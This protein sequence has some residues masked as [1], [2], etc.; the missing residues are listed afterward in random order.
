MENKS[1]PGDRSNEN[2]LSELNYLHQV[3]VEQY[4]EVNKLLNERLN[5]LNSF[6]MMQDVF[7]NIDL[8]GNSELILPIGEIGFATTQMKDNKKILMSVGAGFL[9]EE[10][11]ENAKRIT[12]KY[13][14]KESS[15]IEKL[16]KNKRDIEKALTEITYNLNILGNQ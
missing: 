8:I 9:I 15:E 16:Q 13:I 6:Y 1:N 5:T 12:S 14:A 3:Y 10:D 11:I 2:A 7:E 4:N